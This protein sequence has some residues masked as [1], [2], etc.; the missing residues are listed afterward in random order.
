MFAYG[1]QPRR[2]PSPGRSTGSSLSFQPSSLSHSEVHEP[3]QTVSTANTSISSAAAGGVQACLKTNA[4]GERARVERE[5]ETERDR[6]RE[7]EGER[8]RERERVTQRERNTLL[9]SVSKP[10]DDRYSTVYPSPETTSVRA[11]LANKPDRLSSG[12]RTAPHH[13]RS[14]Q[15]RF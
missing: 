8:E 1:P 4:T 6:D 11:A 7:R 10:R 9:D 13:P 5:R 3:T 2:A 14:T 15:P 12:E